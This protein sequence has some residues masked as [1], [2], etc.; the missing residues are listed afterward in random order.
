ME[1]HKRRGDWVCFAVLEAVGTYLGSTER[2]GKGSS[3]QRA[4]KSSSHKGR[5]LGKEGMRVYLQ[6]NTSSFLN[7]DQIISYLSETQDSTKL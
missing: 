3:L 7:Q 4:S 6:M 2:W 5:A 1:K